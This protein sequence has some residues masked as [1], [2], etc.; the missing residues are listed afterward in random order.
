LQENLE[1]FNL[2]NFQRDCGGARNSTAIRVEHFRAKWEPV[3]VKKM[4]QNK[5]LEPGF[6][7]I[8]TG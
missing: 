7:S 6:D 8:K 5:K 3:R 1:Y 4:R 2:K